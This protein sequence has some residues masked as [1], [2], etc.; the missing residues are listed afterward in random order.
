MVSRGLQRRLAKRLDQL[1]Q[2][3]KETA[4][5]RSERSDSKPLSE[6]ANFKTAYHVERQANARLAQKNRQLEENYQNAKA[7]AEVL[8]RSHQEVTHELTKSKS[9][10]D[11]FEA[12]CM[13]LETQLLAERAERLKLEEALLERTNDQIAL[14]AA[15]SDV[16]AESETY[17]L[18]LLSTHRQFL[19]QRSTLS[20]MAVINQR[21]QATLDAKTAKHD[22]ETQTEVSK[23]EM[24][25][26]TEIIA[27]VLDPVDPIPEEIEIDLENELGRVDD[28]RPAPIEVGSESEVE[29]EDETEYEHVPPVI[30]MSP[31]HL[32]A[33]AKQTTAVPN[34]QNTETSSLRKA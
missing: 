2:E 23:G 26:Q 8:W 32:F 9:E 30:V 21:M 16:H 25:T 12:R 19:A 7:G 14:R 31:S 33:E 6:Q 3:K 22:K 28:I 34:Q 15:L 5:E 27:P 10:R 18:K 1:I 24:E 17:R 20:S 29:D 4:A 13:D 11:A